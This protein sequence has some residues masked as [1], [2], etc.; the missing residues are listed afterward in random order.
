LICVRGFVRRPGAVPAERPPLTVLKPVC[1]AEPM[2]EQALASF[3]EQSY[4]TFQI[5]FGAHHED[6]AAVAVARG[7]Q[8][9]FPDSD[10]AVIVDATQHGANRKIGNLLNMLPHAKH[11]VLVFADSDLHVAPDYLD[12]VVAGLETPGTGLVTTIY[13]AAPA[14]AGLPARL[15]ATHLTH[16]FLP[17]ALLG[18]ALGRQ[19]CLGTTMALHRATLDRLGGLHRL[20]PH[21]ADDYLLAKMVRQL[22][23]DVRLADT[24]PVTTVQDASFAGL[25][26][27]ELRWARTMSALEP[28]TVA[29]ATLQ[30][31]IVWAA[32][33]ILCAGGAAWAFVAFA[34]AWAVRA[35]AG[36]AV[37]RSLRRVAARAPEPP[38][39][40]LL[41]FRDV[42]SA[43]QIVASYWT[44]DVV[45]RGY[46]LRADTA[47][48]A[49]RAETASLSPEEI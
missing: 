24:V 49:F 40:W 22:G 17:G 33:A 8:A 4:P 38:P 9:R 32:L 30:Y 26:R 46:R 39:V 44:D 43:V 35:L 36:V 15:G 28:V 13:T 14:V 34:L 1:G 10:I 16:S 19:D 6:D 29:G 5:V 42:L 3:V 21:L 2:L 25:W 12:R 47:G 41:P 23:L 7:L 18:F 11:D 27:H 31:P 45:W 37:S 20:A 48:D